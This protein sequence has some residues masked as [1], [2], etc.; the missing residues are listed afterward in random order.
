MGKGKGMGTEKRTDDFRLRN[1]LAEILTSA[2]FGQG[3]VAIEILFL[4][5]APFIQEYTALFHASLAGTNE[6]GKGTLDDAKTELGRASGKNTP[7][8]RA[9][10]RTNPNARVEIGSSGGGSK[11]SSRRGSFFIRDEKMLAEKD[12]IDRALR[13]LARQMRHTMETDGGMG[14][15]AARCGGILVNGEW[16]RLKAAKEELHDGDGNVIRTIEVPA[17]CWKYIEAGWKYCPYCGHEQAKL[18]DARDGGK[19]NA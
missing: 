10:D 19:S 14:D 17:G 6:E 7:G 3:R 15:A 9:G 8:R 5:P 13:K 1:Q 11:K 12:R 16:K 4:L 2:G 18:A